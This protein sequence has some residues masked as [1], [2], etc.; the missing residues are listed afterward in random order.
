[1]LS[2]H[3]S[4]K[5]LPSKT[6]LLAV[7]ICVSLLGLA[8][9]M[10]SEQ[11]TAN[12]QQLMITLQ[13][14]DSAAEPLLKGQDQGI[15]APAPDVELIT[16]AIQAQLLDAKTPAAEPWLKVQI[17]SG[18]NLTTLF[19]KANLDANQLYPMLNG[20]KPSK[21]LNRLRPGERLEF[22]IEQGELVKLRHITSP[23]TQTLISRNGDQYLVEAIEFTPEITHNYRQG[24]IDDSLFLSAARA[25]LSQRKIME[26]A[27]IF[28]WDIDFILDIRQ[29]DSFAMVYEERWLDGNDIGEGEIVAAEFINQGKTFQALRYTDKKGNSNYFTPEGK[30]MRKAFLRT[31]VDFS[32]I[33]SKFNPNRKHPIF[34]TR[35][36][37]R[38]VDYAAPTGTPIKTS[39]D[40]K[41]IFAGRKNG[42]GK[43]V[44]VQHG[45]NYTT[46]Y[47]HM[48][49][50]KS[51]MKRGKRVK[52]GQTIGYVGS[53]GYATGPHLH[54]EFR[55]NG[56][57]R[58]PLTV[59]LPQAEALPKAELARF[60]PL[61]NDLLAQLN[62]YRQTQLAKK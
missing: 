2:K 17:R 42:Y 11:V 54:Y 25:G 40:G 51:G 60:K 38:A 24:T 37:H 23:L 35:R 61:A 6:H 47:A 9:L 58:N 8:L 59:P 49:R 27:V 33:S 20:I 41:V 13:A 53:T 32:R 46:L 55:I 44:I 43:V 14:P 12:K 19:D 34:K 56:V 62:D 48:S 50:I 3:P 26:L 5:H 4:L 15:T 57:H 16:A 29:G 21:T 18:D 10:P 28:G 45:Q 52:Q 31:P 1:M 36:P 30:S 7:S 22:L 39:G